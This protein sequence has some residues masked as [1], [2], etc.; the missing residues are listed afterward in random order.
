M[1][2]A[3]ALS[4]GARC[5]LYFLIFFAFTRVLVTNS[6]VSTPMSILASFSRSSSLP[7]RLYFCIK[8]VD[9]KLGPYVYLYLTT[10]P[11]KFRMCDGLCYILFSKDCKVEINFLTI[12]GPFCYVVHIGFLSGERDDLVS[13]IDIK[14][15]CIFDGVFFAVKFDLIFG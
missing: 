8:K 4:T 11:T 15:F 5:S 7:F 3:P 10:S 2:K 9:I 1:L 13:C 12:F 6:P 14:I